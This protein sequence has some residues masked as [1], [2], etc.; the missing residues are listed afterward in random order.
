MGAGGA[1]GNPRI[2]IRAKL[3]SALRRTGAVRQTQIVAGEEIKTASMK[4]IM[5]GNSLTIDASLYF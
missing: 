3:I 1:I 5:S 2:E 4:D